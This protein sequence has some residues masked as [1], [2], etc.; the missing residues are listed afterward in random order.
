MKEK[1]QELIGQPNVWLH[2]KSSNGWVRNVQ[3]LEVTNETLTFRYEHE[4]ENER[5]CWEKTTRIE[6]I[7]EIDVKL[8]AYPKENQ[9]INTLKSK[10]EDL[11]ERE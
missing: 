7:S 11:L 8:I 2:I 10:L 3:I 6:N 1:L 5:R 4:T 9:E